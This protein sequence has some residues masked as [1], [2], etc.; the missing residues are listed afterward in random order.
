MDNFNVKASNI[1]PKIWCSF[2]FCKNSAN[3]AHPWI[4]PCQYFGWWLIITACKRSLRRLCFDRCL[5]VHWGS[6]CQAPPAGRPPGTK[7][8][9]A[10]RPP[11]GRP[12]AGRPP[13]RETSPGRACWEIRSNVKHWIEV[14]FK[15]GVEMRQFTRLIDLYQTV[16]GIFHLLKQCRIILPELTNP[17]LF[18]QMKR[19]VNEW[20]SCYLVA[21]W[22]GRI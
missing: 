3:W 7:T 16:C 1:L 22:S 12:P 20:I 11:A 19:C 6:P 15:Q 9:L 10:R 4:Q 13:H 18:V 2:Q 17:D 14:D 8:H 5:S 21:N